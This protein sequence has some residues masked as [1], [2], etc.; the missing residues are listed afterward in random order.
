MTDSITEFFD[1]T[2]L[3][4]SEQQQISEEEN[5][6]NVVAV[7]KEAI[8]YDFKLVMIRQAYITLAKKMIS[9]GSSKLLIGT[10]IDFPLGNSSCEQKLDEIE[11]AINLGADEIDIVINYTAFIRGNISEITD[12]IIKCTSLCLK[13]DKIT[14]WIIESAALNMDEISSLCALIKETVIQNFGM[15][16][17]EKVFVKSSTGFFKTKDGSPSGATEEGIKIMIHH[18]SPLPVKASG[19][20]RNRIEFD[21]MINLGVKRVGTS[22]A[23]KILKGLES[24]SDY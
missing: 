10:V 2:Y 4:T 23:L 9:D 22:S 12:E 14:K 8:D 3:K 7:I 15:E 20:I 13:N 6:V 21:R 11:S 24:D 16:N 18:S 5:I 17:T 19:G 1:S